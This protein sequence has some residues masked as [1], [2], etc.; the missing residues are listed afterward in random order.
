M[1]N[2]KFWKLDF[3]QPSDASRPLPISSAEGTDVF[4]RR[5]TRLLSPSTQVFRRQRATLDSSPLRYN[6]Q[7]PYKR[8]T[9][10]RSCA[11][12]IRVAVTRYSPAC[13][14]QAEKIEHHLDVP[15]AA[16]TTD[17]MPMLRHVNKDHIVPE[18]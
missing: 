16:L 6:C 7:A 8:D 13:L 14:A 11:A 2:A 18:L 17:E 9:N 12:Y 3:C 4:P 5:R 15:P 1:K 10:R